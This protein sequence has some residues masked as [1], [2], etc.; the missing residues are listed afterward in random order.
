MSSTSQLWVYHPSVLFVVLDRAIGLQEA[1]QSVERTPDLAESSETT[2]N[3]HP[4]GRNSLDGRT[5]R[6]G[7]FLAEIGQALG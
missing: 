3:P 2:P 7:Y 4:H 1:E 5:Q 6:L